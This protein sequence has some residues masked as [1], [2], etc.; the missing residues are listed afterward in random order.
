MRIRKSGLSSASISDDTASVP[1]SLSRISRTISRASGLSLDR[2]MIRVEIARLSLSLPRVCA[3]SL[4]S[5]SATSPHSRALLNA[6][7]NDSVACGS[8]RSANAR[9]AEIRTSE[10]ESP[11]NAAIKACKDSSSL[12]FPKK[13]AAA[14][15]SLQSGACC[16][17]WT[18]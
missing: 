6:E 10:S 9:A 5:A 14:S 8:P 3:Y 7:I 16:R 1:T 18:Y 15:R 12:S 17:S 2:P 4:N 11:H 13:A